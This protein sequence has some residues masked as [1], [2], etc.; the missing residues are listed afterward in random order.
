LN[1][2]E[3]NTVAIL[4]R[5]DTH[6]DLVV[7]A[8]QA[9]KHVFVE[10]PLAIDQQGLDA[11][12]KVLSTSSLSP[13]TSSP[14]TGKLLLVGFNRRFSPLAVELS[15]FLSKCTEP[16]YMHYRVNAGLIPLTHW[17]QDPLQGGGRIIGEGCHFI[18]LLTFLAGA[19]PLAVSANALP[20]GGKYREDNVSM[21][22][23]FPDGSVG[24]VD[25]L[26]NGDKSFPKERLEV[27]CGGSVAVLDDFR[28]LEMTREGKRTRLKKAQDKGWHA[29]WVAFTDAIK[30]GG[31]PPIPY[32][33][34][35]GVTKAT[36]AAV[37]SLRLSGQVVMIQAK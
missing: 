20:D 23:S 12:V 32:D 2:P 28:S 15:R 17:T 7:K 29:E 11:I 24:V 34:L 14:D 6:A 21:T 27:F 4:T 18:D 3:I 22:F 16:L 36:F 1:D 31:P 8:L 9:G 26:A 25:Y 10:K 19:A 33:Q 35:I 30:A 37:E 13:D 5:H